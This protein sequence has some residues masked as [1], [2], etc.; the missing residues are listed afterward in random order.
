MNKIILTATLLT[1][2]TFISCGDDDSNSDCKLCSFAGNKIEICDNENGTAS[3][4]AAGDTQVYKLSDGQ[5]FDNLKKDICNGI[6]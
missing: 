1:S 6:F 3:V 5:T 2:I 4:T